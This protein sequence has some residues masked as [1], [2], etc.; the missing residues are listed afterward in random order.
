MLD[1]SEMIVDIFAGGGGASTGIYQAT[2][3]HPD[4]AINHD[5]TAISVHASN[6]PTTNHACA[7]VWEVEPRAAVAG[8]KVGL[9]WAS[10]DCRHFS[11][12]S[13]GRPKWKSVRALPGVVITWAT[14]VRPR[15]IV[16]ENVREMQGWGPLLDDGTP[17]PDRI[18]RS[19]R[20]WV[21]RL[22]G[23]GYTL[24]WRELC[25]ADYGIPTIRTR[26]FV[27]ARCDG[28]PITWPQPTHG[29]RPGM[30]EAPWRQAAEII[31]WSIPCPSIFTREKP[32][33]A[34][35]L[36]RVA[37]GIRRYVLGTTPFL[38]SLGDAP[39]FS[40]GHR[41]TAS[42]RPART[43]AQR[44]LVAAFLAQHNLHAV[45]SSLRQPVST[46]TTSGSQQQLVTARLANDDIQGAE[47]VSAFLMSYYSKGGQHQPISAPLGTVTTHDHFALVTVAGQEVP[48][49][50]IGMRML[51]PHELAAA[52]GFPPD[53][54]LQ[55]R[56]TGEAISKK[57]QV[58]LIGNSV[59][60]PIAE[61][62]IRAMI[63]ERNER[64]AA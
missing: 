17:C 63:K 12:A 22:R 3:R 40:A 41:M 56:N 31:D 27:V 52:Q 5:Q 64:L 48:I 21:G 18:G 25:A 7:S 28:Q 2:G 26:L 55:H 38:V 1:P 60:P 33:V 53:Y 13:G 50:D 23:L 29:K 10:P 32:L 15:I 6:H 24:D 19:F 30:F 49:I 58:R 35:T 14:R 20:W 61:A 16:V 62:V 46:L 9:L 54:V 4:L 39:T 42:A 43:S 37:K 8:R 57:D 59:C 34:A 44:N 45:G 11:R 47:R 51:R 36:Q